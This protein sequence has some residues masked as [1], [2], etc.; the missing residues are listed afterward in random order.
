[1]K[2]LVS[3]LL[4]LLLLVTLESRADIT[5]LVIDTGL[6]SQRADLTKY[7]PKTYKTEYEDFHGHGTHVISLILRKACPEVKIIP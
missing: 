6:S 3:I 5:V 4:A 7:V 1:M 2:Y